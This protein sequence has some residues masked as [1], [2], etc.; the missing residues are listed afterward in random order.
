[1]VAPPS[2]RLISIPGQPPRT[3][4][5]PRPPPSVRMIAIARCIHTIKDNK[6]Q[7]QRQSETVSHYLIFRFH[8]F[9]FCN[10]VAIGVASPPLIRIPAPTSTAQRTFQP[11]PPLASSPCSSRC[12]HL[13]SDKKSRLPYGAKKVFLQNPSVMGVHLHLRNK[14]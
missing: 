13:S 8:S 1:M 7:N 11:P 4:R 14:C 12:F 3:Q 9:T 2:D 10:E 5:T 6:K